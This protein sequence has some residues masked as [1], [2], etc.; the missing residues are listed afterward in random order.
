LPLL[1]LALRTVR[2]RPPR[3]L[4]LSALALRPAGAL[5][6]S[7]L[8]S[9]LRAVG[10]VSVAAA[11]IASAALAALTL[12]PAFALLRLTAAIVV[13]RAALAARALLLGA[14]FGALLGALR[15]VVAP[16]GPL[17]ASAAAARACRGTIV[18][19]MLHAQTHPHRAR[20]EPK[21]PFAPLVQHFNLVHFVK[22]N[23][24]LFEGVLHRFLAG[25]PAGFNCF[26]S[27]V[28]SSTGPHGPG[29]RGAL[30]PVGDRTGP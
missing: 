5:L 14:P 9:L 17:A 24:Q 16:F 23:A 29:C 25:F 13:A 10:T 11:V 26:H 15:S 1:R 21:Q 19:Q 28:V 4:S 2:A 20:S 7:L 6:L 30:D 12:L 22:F 8:L 3:L 27:I 18:F